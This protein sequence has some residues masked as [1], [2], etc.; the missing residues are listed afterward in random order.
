MKKGSKKAAKKL[1]K[2]TPSQIQL[3]TSQNIDNEP[4]IRDSNK[5]S[6]IQS[7]QILESEAKL[8]SANLPINQIQLV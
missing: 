2:P 7:N 4:N 1:V 3:L 6:T 5:K 8:S